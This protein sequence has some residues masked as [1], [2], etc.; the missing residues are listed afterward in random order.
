MTTLDD[1]PTT[2]TVEALPRP[3]YGWEDRSACLTAD[4]D[5]HLDHT[6]QEE[7]KALCR[8][9]P[10]RW[11]CLMRTVRTPGE[12]AVRGAMTEWERRQWL[13]EEG[14][15]PAPEIDWPHVEG[16]LKAGA[17][18]PE[19]GAIYGLKAAAIQKRYERR[20][21]LPKPRRGPTPADID[22]TT[23]RALLAEG[24]SQTEVAERLGTSLT[25]LRR[26]L[27]RE[28]QARRVS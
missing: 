9:C 14:L 4:P 10:V 23:A 20:H 1:R 2:R 26:A 28:E 24:F 12:I 8:T 11:D 18:W 19:I 13:A 15:G 7:A 17:G 5:L 21:Q 3:R 6:R 16:M 27:R 25:T 22:T